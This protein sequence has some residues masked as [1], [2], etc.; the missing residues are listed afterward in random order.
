M[1]AN[2]KG[3]VSLVERTWKIRAMLLEETRQAIETLYG[4]DAEMVAR[5]ARSPFGKEAAMEP[6]QV[7][8][9]LVPGE[10]ELQPKRNLGDLLRGWAGPTDGGNGGTS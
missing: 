2:A 3:R 10:L 6:W 5:A 9:A 4:V 7:L 1:L 8:E